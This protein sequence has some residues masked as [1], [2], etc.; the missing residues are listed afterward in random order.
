MET[1]NLADYTT[2]RTPGTAAAWY[3]LDTT[4]YSRELEQLVKKYDQRCILAGGS[5]TLFI[6]D[7]PGLVIHVSLRGLEILEETSDHVFIRVG[8]GEVWDALVA[9]SLQKG[10]YGLENLSLIPGTVGAAPVQNIG[11]YGKEAKDFIVRVDG[12][13]I[14]TGVRRSFT[15][16]SCEF[17]YRMSTF[18][19]NLR[20]S[21]VITHVVFRLS[22]QPVT[23]ISYATLA[24]ELEQ[25][26]LATPS[27]QDVRDAV[28]RVRSARLPD[29]RKIPNAGSFFMNPIVPKA[30][31]DTLRAKHPD[32]PVYPT[33]SVEYLKLS[34]AWL[35]DQA[36]LKGHW[37]G[38]VGTYQTQPLVL[39]TNGEASG[40]EIMAFA[41]DIMST[42]QER[43]GV[44]LTPEV[45]RVGHE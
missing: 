19:K 43:F 36:G 11:A 40:A 38:N 34:A 3:E 30:E 35:I 24:S 1:R 21:F 6:G 14:E 22:K 28:I 17:G 27:P 39:V 26:G 31:A 16:A 5:N 8:A 37:S 13:E 20:N 15:N 12:V 18:K 32:L 10:W 44:T 4:E 23:E 9:H 45:T 2:L 29:W 33:D 42:V 25:R 41:H 7:F